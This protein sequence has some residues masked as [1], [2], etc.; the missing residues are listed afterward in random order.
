M[1][2]CVHALTK[3]ATELR[4]QYVLTYKSTTERYERQFRRIEVKLAGGTSE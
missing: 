1:R 4:D 3:L 2:L